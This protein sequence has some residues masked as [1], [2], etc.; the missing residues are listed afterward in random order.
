MLAYYRHAVVRI[1]PGLRRGD[2]FGCIEVVHP[3]A[4]AFDPVRVEVDRC[5]R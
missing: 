2:G 3:I 5:V 4:L 1:G